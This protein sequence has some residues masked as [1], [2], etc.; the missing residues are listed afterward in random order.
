MT[1]AVRFALCAAATVPDH[2]PNAA[3]TEPVD[4]I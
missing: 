1:F 4:L 2:A 3:N